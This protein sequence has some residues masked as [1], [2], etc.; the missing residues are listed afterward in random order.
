[1][2]ET[3]YLKM[4][5]IKPRQLKI[6]MY[7]SEKYFKR[8]HNYLKTSQAINNN[9]YSNKNDLKKH[10]FY[11]SRQIDPVEGY[12]MCDFAIDIKIMIYVNR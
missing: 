10:I 12:S 6:I 3:V 7:K 1:M 9:F 8:F 4:Y 2:H 5:K 11:R